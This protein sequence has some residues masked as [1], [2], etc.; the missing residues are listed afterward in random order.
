VDLQGQQSN[1]RGGP[2]AVLNGSL[3]SDVLVVSLAPGAKLQQP[4]HLL[5]VS[6]PA[7]A[8]AG[9]SVPTL[10]ASAARLLISLGDNTSCEVV[11][12]FVSD[13]AGTHVS[14][15]VAEVVLGEGSELKHGYVHREAA[16]A[17][18]YKATL[19]SQVCW[20]VG[21]VGKSGCWHCAGQQVG[22][23][24]CSWWSGNC[25]L[26]LVVRQ[27]HQYRSTPVRLHCSWNLQQWWRGDCKQAAARPRKV[28]QPAAQ[29][30]RRC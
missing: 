20:V 3:A 26:Q 12:E 28:L 19:V 14:M 9:S 25:L 13:A 22:S 23:D 21:T 4:L 17:Q 7:A 1:A 16:G 10:N 15:P 8:D 5:H 6:T 2:F 24:C 29:L 11:E 27:T 30:S 18:H